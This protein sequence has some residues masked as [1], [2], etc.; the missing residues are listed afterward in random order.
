MELEV[1]MLEWEL[2]MVYLRKANNLEQIREGHDILQMGL[3]KSASG[4]SIQRP[5]AL[6]LLVTD[7]K[8]MNEIF[9]QKTNATR[10]LLRAHLRCQHLELEAHSVHFCQL[11]AKED[12][13]QIRS[14]CGGRRPM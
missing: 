12:A 4:N 6:D 1:N 10:S 13:T 14:Q 8:L 3:S 9:V 7:P 2:E 5:R 11:K